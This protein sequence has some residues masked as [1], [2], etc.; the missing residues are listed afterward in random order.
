MKFNNCIKCGKGVSK[1]CKKGYCNACR[2]RSGKNNPFW[3]KKHSKEIMD[4]IKRGNSIAFKKLWKTKE[5]REKVIKGISKPRRKSFKKEQSDRV[6]EWY[7]NNL[8]QK[9][10]RSIE[11]KKNWANGK[12]E[13][14]I[15]SINE[16]KL[17][18][19]FRAELKK[20]F[21]KNNVKKVTI[22]IKD[23]WFYP[24]VKIDKDFIVEF[25]GDYWHANPHI[26]KANGIVHH[27]LTAQQIWHN[28]IKREEILKKNGFRVFNVWQDEWKNNRK[29]ILRI[30]KANL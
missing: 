28:D 8:I 2:D 14:N 25:Y 21:P 3:G 11:M 15:N 13:P 1:N 20:L 18:K 29:N 27:G 9:E 4:R 5:Y 17:E 30:I 10:I 23:K 16:S 24:D 12:I 6:K 22:K 26:F 19:N 7:K